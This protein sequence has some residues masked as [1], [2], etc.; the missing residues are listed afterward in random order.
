[1]QE[2]ARY[3]LIVPP[4]NLKFAGRYTL[5]EHF[6]RLGLT[7]HVAMESAN[8]ELSYRYVELGL[9]LAFASLAGEASDWR[10]RQLVF[11]PLDEYFPT[12]YLAVVMRPDKT[13]TTYKTAFLNL[14]FEKHP[15]YLFP[16]KA[17]E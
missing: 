16:T 11:I 15:N 12:D 6:A 9:G 2:I 13:L 1:M 4:A 7:Y 17:K 14:L 8:V 5:E 10:H 3:P